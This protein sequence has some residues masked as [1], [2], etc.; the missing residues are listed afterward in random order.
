MANAFA[1]CM[2]TAA[3]MALPLAASLATPPAAHPGKYTHTTESQPKEG[4][5]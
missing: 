5:A 4:S 1:S 2:L 3:G